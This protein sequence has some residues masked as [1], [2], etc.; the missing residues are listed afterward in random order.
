MVEWNKL[1]TQQFVLFQNHYLWSE[2]EAAFQAFLV[3]RPSMI[4]KQ[5]H[6]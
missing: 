4:K 3:P 1:I 2:N 5:K 6:G